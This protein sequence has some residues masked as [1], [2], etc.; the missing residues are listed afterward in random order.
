MKTMMLMAACA[1]LVMS[2][3]GAQ[4]ES[5]FTG[6]TAVMPLEPTDRRWTT[7]GGEISDMLSTALVNRGLQMVERMQLDKAIDEIGIGRNSGMFDTATVSKVGKM[8]GTQY[9]VLG[10]ISEF[11]EAKKN[12]GF[13]IGG[14]G[15]GDNRIE[16]RVKLDVRVV[17]VKT[18]II[19][20][21]GTGE[22]IETTKG[23]SFNFEKLL[24]GARLDNSSAEWVESR[25]GKA[26]RKAVE[27]LA[28][29]LVKKLEE[30]STKSSGE[31][32]S[33]P[34][35]PEELTVSIQVN[36][37]AKYTAAKR[38][39]DALGQ[40]KGVKAAKLAD[41]ND[42]TLKVEVTVAKMSIEMLAEL[43]EESSAL[44]TFDLNVKNVKGD[45]ITANAGK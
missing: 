35:L 9:L 14:V 8:L 34:S 33:T 26:S 16:G 43:L 28:A 32:G 13:V 17:N 21:A 29:D 39:V 31:I 24:G 10:R 6:R 4:A 38:L 36:S 2:G 20:A 5:R 41:F 11:G 37:M 23:S 1:A 30:S 12:K 22:G 7:L 3:A 18:G 15:I 40:L 42:G 19:V 44:K 45:E 25:L 27:A